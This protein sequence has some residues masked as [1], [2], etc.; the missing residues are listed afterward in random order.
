[1]ERQGFLSKF[2]NKPLFIL[3]ALLVPTLM[4]ADA[5]QSKNA[6]VKGVSISIPTILPSEFPTPIYTPTP[7]PEPTIYIP[8]PTIT[9][10][11]TKISIIYVA[12][13]TVIQNIQPTAVQNSGLDNNK[14]YINVDG[15][16][17]HSPANSNDGSVPAGA[18]ARCRD[19]TYSFSKHRKGTCSHH[20]GVAAWL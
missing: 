11:P 15:N 17:I 20:G 13:T 8:I 4:V 5:N 6:D 10:I 1:M 14:T 16:Q 9:P 19:G 2:K 12:P 7:T 18:T 3:L